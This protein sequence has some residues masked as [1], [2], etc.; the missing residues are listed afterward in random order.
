MFHIRENPKKKKKNKTEHAKG[1]KNVVPLKSSISWDSICCFSETKPYDEVLFELG[2]S[3][4]LFENI[5]K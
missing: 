5:T 3:Q 1:T 4:S 2:K